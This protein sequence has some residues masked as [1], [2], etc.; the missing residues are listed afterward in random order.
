MQ[1]DS[2]SNAQCAFADEIN[3]CVNGVNVDSK[4]GLTGGIFVPL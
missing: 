3:I 1:N 2:D 4:L